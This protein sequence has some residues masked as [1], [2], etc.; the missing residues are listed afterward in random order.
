MN[1]KLFRPHGLFCLLMT[2]KPDKESSGEPVMVS[3]IIGKTI[4]PAN[5][6]FKE[7]LKLLTLT[8]GVTK[9]E[10]ELP[11]AAPL[12]YPALDDVLEEGGE[13]KN[14]FARSSDFAAKYLDRRA[15]AKYVCNMS[16]FVP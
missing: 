13:K 4:T 7:Q 15:H 1:E 5:S 2:Y 14:A 10:M 3:S 8:S 9:G 12:I 16:T 11:E 6:K